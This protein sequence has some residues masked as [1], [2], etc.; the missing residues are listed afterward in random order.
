MK[1]VGAGLGND[2]HVGAGVSSIAG[3]VSGRLNLELLQ[4]IRIRDADPRIDAG[5]LAEIV[6]GEVIYVDAVH[7]VVI[8]IYVRA[9]YGHIGRAL[10]KCGSVIDARAYTRRQ[11]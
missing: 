2:V 4:R 7:H 9:V 3:I 8:L 6:A 10:S 1:R 5:V 11:G